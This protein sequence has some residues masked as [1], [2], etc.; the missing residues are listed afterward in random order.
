MMYLM[1][2]D[3]EVWVQQVLNIKKRGKNYNEKFKT[4]Y[5]RSIHGNDVSEAACDT[6]YH[7]KT[8]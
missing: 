5:K 2:V 1:I 7:C 8:W 4:G 6:M 3:L